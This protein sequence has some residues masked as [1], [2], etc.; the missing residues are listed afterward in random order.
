VAT[1]PVGS[2]L[3]LVW[4]VVE[5]AVCTYRRNAAGQPYH[6]GCDPDKP[7]RGLP[8]FNPALLVCAV[9]DLR[10]ADLLVCP[11]GLNGVGA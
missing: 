6:P 8:G 4:D 2:S 7:A 10:P 1:K 5:C 3:E 9:A 11:L